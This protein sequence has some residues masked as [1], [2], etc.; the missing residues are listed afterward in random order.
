MNVIEKQLDYLNDTMKETASEANSFLLKYH[1][2]GI[3]AVLTL[4]N[5]DLVIAKDLNVDTML[6][7]IILLISIFLAVFLS[8]KYFEFVLRH[9][10]RF[11][12][13]HR[14]L[15]YKY[16]L[17]LHSLLSK[18][19]NEEYQYYLEQSLDERSAFRKEDDDK[20]SEPSKGYDFKYIAHYLLNHHRLRYRS[21]NKMDNSYLRI[22][23]TVVIL[24]VLIRGILLLLR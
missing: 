17:T 19:S 10:S 22:A 5:I 1:F 12:K 11:A 21:L 15:K 14:K 24:T 8:Y 20:I 13:S 3:I 2:G 23:L 6:D 4:L 7:H 16:E 9:Y 18:G